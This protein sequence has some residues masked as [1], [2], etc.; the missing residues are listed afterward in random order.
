MR[1]EGQGAGFRTVDE[2]WLD[3]GVLLGARLEVQRSNRR[4]V[5]DR[6]WFRNHA[7]YRWTD[8]RGRVLNTE[9]RSTQFEVRMMRARLDTLLQRL[10]DDT[11]RLPRRSAVRTD[12]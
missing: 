8:G 2:Y 1:V 10:N 4:P 9:S 7:L 12:P 3:N 11:Q 5:A 6:I